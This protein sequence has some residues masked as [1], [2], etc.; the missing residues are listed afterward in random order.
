MP[1]SLYTSQD[2]HDAYK[3]LGTNVIAYL[4]RTAELTGRVLV[5]IKSGSI[6]LKPMDLSQFSL[7]TGARRPLFAVRP[8]PESW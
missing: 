1:I 6:R 8:P 4:Q 5:D 3:T 7:S 2:K